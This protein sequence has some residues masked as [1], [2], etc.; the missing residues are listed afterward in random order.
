MLIVNRWRA[1]LLTWPCHF[2]DFWF[3]SNIWCEPVKDEGPSSSHKAFWLLC[4]CHFLFFLPPIVPTSHSC[5]P[6]VVLS[7]YR[8]PSSSSLCVLLL[9]MSQ[10][11]PPLR[12]LRWAQATSSCLHIFLESVQRE[13]TSPARHLHLNMAPIPPGIRL[14]VS[15]DRDQWWVRICVVT[16]CVRICSEFQLN[17]WKVTL[18]NIL[19]EFPFLAWTCE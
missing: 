18:S 3:L 8:F 14:L 6:L 16:L 7:G 10:Q 13:L 4:Y 2:F 12:E 17:D 5:P 15:F 11:L 19:Y 1:L 9:T